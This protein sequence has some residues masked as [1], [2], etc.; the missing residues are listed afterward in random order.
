MEIILQKFRNTL[1]LQ[2]HSKTPINLLHAY[3]DIIAPKVLRGIP[4]VTC[5]G[6]EQ[7]SRDVGSEGAGGGGAQ[8]SKK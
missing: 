1:I 3:Q 4:T 8:I 5:T 7:P 2:T 6:P